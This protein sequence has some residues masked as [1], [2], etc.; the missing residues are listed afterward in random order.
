V[1]GAWEKYQKVEGGG[2]LESEIRRTW[3]ER[4]RTWKVSS[5][6]GSASHELCDPGAVTDLS[7]GLSCLRCERGI[8]ASQCPHEAGKENCKER[9]PKKYLVHNR[10]LINGSHDCFT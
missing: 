9:G 1:F 3:D 10:C 2:G 8:S 7:L 5:E 4:T 6:L